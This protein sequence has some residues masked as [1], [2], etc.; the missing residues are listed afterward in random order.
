ML[1]HL[2][3]PNNRLFVY[4][5]CRA[6]NKTLQISYGYLIRG[7]HILLIEQ[8][9]M[10]YNISNLRAA[11]IKRE[12]ILFQ[13]IG[14]QLGDATARDTTLLSKIETS[15]SITLF[16]IIFTAKYLIVFSVQFYLCL[17]L[18]LFHYHVFI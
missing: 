5:L 10:A 9:F 17:V 6:R 15:R 13:P 4:V 11:S 18:G 12:T 2:T 8:V 16:E 7:C 14:K 1:E 3:F